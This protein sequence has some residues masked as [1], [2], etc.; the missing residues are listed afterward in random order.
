MRG[1]KRRAQNFGIFSHMQEFFSF[2]QTFR[3]GE[4]PPFPPGYGYVSDPLCFDL[5]LVF[6]LVKSWFSLIRCTYEGVQC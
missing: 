5:G 3:G 4:F 6:D 1:A 2:T